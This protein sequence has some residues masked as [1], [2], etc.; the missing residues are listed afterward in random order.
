M[1]LRELGKTLEQHDPDLHVVLKDPDSGLIHVLL[2][3]LEDTAAINGNHDLRCGPHNLTYRPSGQDAPIL[4]LG[5]QS[6]YGNYPATPEV[7][8]A[9]KLASE[10]AKRDP[11]LRAVITHH[12]DEFVDVDLVEIVEN[13]SSPML[14]GNPGS[15]LPAWPKHV[16]KL[17]SRALL[18]SNSENEAYAQL[19]KAMRQELETG[20]LLVNAGRPGY[21]GKDPL[22]LGD[23]GVTREKLRQDHRR[24]IDRT[25]AAWENLRQAVKGQPQ[26]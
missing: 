10:L 5:R 7:D 20:V 3:I 12:F 13:T 26:P 6:W 16:D 9:G 4:H 19:R 15:N 22:P 21:Q 18:V 25:H 11:D 17:P 23:R 14:W 2:C 24:A 1:N 8:T